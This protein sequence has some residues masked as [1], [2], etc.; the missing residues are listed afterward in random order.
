MQGV[1]QEVRIYL[2]LPNISLRNFL[3]NNQHYLDI[4]TLTKQPKLG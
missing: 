3:A 4:K 1:N 2:K